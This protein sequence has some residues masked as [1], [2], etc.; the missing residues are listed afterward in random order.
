MHTP[1]S[2]AVTHEVT[3]SK[4]NQFWL[5]PGIFRSPEFV[6]AFILLLAHL[7][8]GPMS[9]WNPLCVKRTNS[10]SLNLIKIT[11]KD[12]IQSL[13][14]NCAQSPGH[15]V[16]LQTHFHSSDYW[17]VC[18]YVSMCYLHTIWGMVNIRFLML[19]KCGYHNCISWSW[20]VF[21]TTSKDP[22]DIT[23]RWYS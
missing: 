21:T 23:H 8:K 3:L 5:T 11:Y 1:G 16:I 22:N 12:L 17:L 14:P 19:I 4:L 13:Q 10:I 9:L 20:S 18:L 2:S 7:A 6:T 15:I